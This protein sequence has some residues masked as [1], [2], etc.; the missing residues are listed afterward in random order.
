MGLTTNKLLWADGQ[1]VVTKQA[2]RMST[3]SGDRLL[4]VA[5]SQPRAQP[6]HV[7]VTQ[8][9]ACVQDTG[10]R[11]VM[12]E[13]NHQTTVDIKWWDEPTDRMNMKVGVPGSV[14]DNFRK[15]FMIYR[16][17]TANLNRFSWNDASIYLNNIKR[18]IIYSDNIS[19]AAWVTKWQWTCKGKFIFILPKSM[20]TELFQSVTIF[21]SY[22]CS[23]EPERK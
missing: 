2:G 11:K 10:N 14:C 9:A 15:W 23:S 7:A 5:V 22:L 1:D 4:E 6:L 17:R 3:Y 20:K 12:K 8:Q 13:A 18:A 19:S 16:F 21:A